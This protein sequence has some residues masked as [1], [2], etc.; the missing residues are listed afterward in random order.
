M[1]PVSAATIRETLECLREDVPPAGTKIGVLAT[2]EIV[3]AVAAFLSSRGMDREKIVLDPVVY[4]SSGW[5]LLS[6]DGVSRMRAE[7][8]DQAGWVTPNLDELALLA[9][10]G[11]LQRKDVPEAALNLQR[12]HPR[13]NVL[14]TGGHLDRPDDFLLLTSGESFWLEGERVETTST[15]GTGCALSSALLCELI[16][17]KGPKEAALQ[18]KVYVTQALKAAYP[19]GRGRGPMNHLFR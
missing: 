19:V 3:G 8:L 5:E 16:A 1:E 14:V 10:T 9:Q 6:P 18:A 11:P 7:L 17:G 2:A 4:S 12:I 13:L 15:H